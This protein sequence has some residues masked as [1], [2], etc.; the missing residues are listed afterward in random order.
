MQEDGHE[1][2]ALAL[3]HR[4][5]DAADLD[6][7]TR[8]LLEFAGK[9]T[10][11]AYKITDGDIERLR[12]LG[13]SDAQLAECVLDAAL[14]NM[15]D[16]VADAFGITHDEEEVQRFSPDRPPPGEPS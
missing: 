11:E 6:A 3:A 10:E 14:F 4:N 16:R 15:L 12:K 8:A 13:W 5:L 9:V 2:R 7:P 1:K